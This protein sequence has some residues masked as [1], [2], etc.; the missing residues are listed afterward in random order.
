MLSRIIRWN[1]T[2]TT[3]KANE[4]RSRA[5]IIRELNAI[6]NLERTPTSPRP[7]RFDGNIVVALHDVRLLKETIYL[8]RDYSKKM[9]AKHETDIS[10]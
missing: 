3:R 8:F 7:M 6:I 4:Y 10:V 9:R 1:V 2:K 5:C